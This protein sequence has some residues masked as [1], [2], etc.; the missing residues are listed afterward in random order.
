MDRVTAGKEDGWPV[1]EARKI[2]VT[3]KP[4]VV[5]RNDKGFAAYSA[6]CTHLGC[7]VHWNG[8]KREFECPCHAAVFD[9]EGKVVSGPPPSA[10]PPYSASVVQGEVIVSPA[11]SG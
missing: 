8:S 11:K 9:A 2:S 10:L 4:V 5:V 6:I 7:I 1:W 3:G